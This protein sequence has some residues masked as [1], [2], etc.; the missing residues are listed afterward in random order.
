MLSTQL[1]LQTLQPLSDLHHTSSF[2]SYPHVPQLISEPS[3]RHTGRPGCDASPIAYLLVIDS[4]SMAG[5]HAGTA[6][7]II[8][9]YTVSSIM[10][11]V[12]LLR[13]WSAHPSLIVPKSRVPPPRMPCFVLNQVAASGVSVK[14]KHAKQLGNWQE[15]MCRNFAV[16]STSG[17]LLLSEAQKLAAELFRGRASC[18]APPLLAMANQGHAGP[19]HPTGKQNHSKPFPQPCPQYGASP[20]HIPH[21]PPPAMSL[22]PCPCCAR[23]GKDMRIMDER[24]H[25]LHSS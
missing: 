22:T 1:P 12:L 6:E 21:R 17:V 15:A 8:L 23:G 4:F 9:Q 10:G 14:S 24:K 13:G 11:P 19:M 2:P 20:S 16:L 18:T 25:Q 3:A 7:I 5:T